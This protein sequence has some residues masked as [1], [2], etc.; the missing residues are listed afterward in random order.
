[1]VSTGT[2]GDNV[3]IRFR[4]RPPKSPIE[5]REMRDTDRVHLQTDNPGPWFLHC[6]ID[7]HAEAGLGV[8]LAVDTNTTSK[9]TTTDAW[10]DLCPT[11]NALSSDDL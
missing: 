2:L 11:Y 9:F 4:V 1:M 8:V 3:T 6:H 5:P 7:P 10:K